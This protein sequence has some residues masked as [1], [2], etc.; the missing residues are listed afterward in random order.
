MDNMIFD[1]NR[2]IDKLAYAEFTAGQMMTELDQLEKK[3]DELEAENLD[4]QLALETKEKELVEALEAKERNWRWYMDL[5][6]KVKALEQKLKDEG[7]NNVLH[8]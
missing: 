3:V 4:L 5:D 7:E 1:L 8:G 2:V 6:K